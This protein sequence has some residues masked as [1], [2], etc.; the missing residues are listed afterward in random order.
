MRALFAPPILLA[1]ALALGLAACSTPQIHSTAKVRD[2]H[3]AA[4]DLAR[5]G[6]AFV[7]PSSV[8]GQE[9]DRQALAFAFT[10]VI[11]SSR[12]DLRIVA[13]PDTLSAINRAGLIDDYRKLAEDY[14]ITGIFSRDILARLAQAAGVRYVAQLKLAGFRQ[15]SRERWG[16]LGLRLFDTKSAHLRLFLQI[17]DS[18]DG[19]VAWEGTEEITS[20]YDSMAETTI[21][22]RHA[23][24]QAAHELVQRMP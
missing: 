20:S 11:K 19:S 15:E 10:E 2:I 12:P 5:A 3:L 7:T 24:E 22:L 17:W 21:T 13:L 1:A 8:T 9:E 4:P 6:I 23:T 18:R 16:I 14:R